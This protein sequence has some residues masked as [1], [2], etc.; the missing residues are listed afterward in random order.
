M[1]EAPQEHP[2]QLRRIVLLKCNLS[3]TLF[4]PEGASAT[5]PSNVSFEAEIAR[6]DDLSSLLVRCRFFTAHQ[7][8]PT[9]E[10]D[11]VWAAEFA[12]PPDAREEDV[13][14]FGARSGTFVVWPY[15]RAHIADLTARMGVPV[16]QLPTIIIPDLENDAAS[17]DEERLP[18]PGT[19]NTDREERTTLLEP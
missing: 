10:L 7:D 2:W 8:R 14:E 13:V 3:S 12:T 1:L 16:L 5:V 18:D 15:A 11:V 19:M 6:S 4:T 9:Y 17:Q